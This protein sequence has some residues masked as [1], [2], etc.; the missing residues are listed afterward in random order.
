MFSTNNLFKKKNKNYHKISPRLFCETTKFSRFNLLEIIKSS[1]F[2]CPLNS[3]RNIEAWDLI[4]ESW[5]WIS[6][7]IR[8]K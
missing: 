5:I 4:Y 8:G 3:R 6:I 2:H 7:F 1:A